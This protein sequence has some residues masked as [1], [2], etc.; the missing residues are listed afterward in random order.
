M[1][2]KIDHEIIKELAAHEFDA[3]LERS[4]LLLDDI[5]IDA[6]DNL[7]EGFVIGYVRALK[8]HIIN[9]SKN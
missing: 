8:E 4:N 3:I 9:Q 5:G 1:G 7:I 2:I 6:Y